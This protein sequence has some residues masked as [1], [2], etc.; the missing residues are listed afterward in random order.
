MLW[1]LGFWQIQTERFSNWIEL[2]RSKVVSSW[3]PERSLLQTSPG[4]ESRKSEVCRIW[5]FHHDSGP[6][7]SFLLWL[8]SI[9]VLKIRRNSVLPKDFQLLC[10]WSA[11]VTLYFYKPNASAFASMHSGLTK[12]WW[13]F[14][15]FAVSILCVPIYNSPSF[16][17]IWRLMSILRFF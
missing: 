9:V 2:K 8:R 15:I 4:H 7:K 1:F 17:A 16:W 12:D 14:S 11:V 5:I 6:K 10:I 3:D 13:L